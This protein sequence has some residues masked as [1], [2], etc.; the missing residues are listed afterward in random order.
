[1]NRPC[2]PSLDGPSYHSRIHLVTM[3]LIACHVSCPRTS[4]RIERIKRSRLWLSASDFWDFIKPS[5]IAHDLWVRVSFHCRDIEAV[6]KI[7]MRIPSI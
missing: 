5:I 4:Q 2:M 6:F 1:M 3:V 7:E